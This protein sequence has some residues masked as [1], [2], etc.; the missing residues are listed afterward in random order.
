[1]NKS[2]KMNQ[3]T[4]NKITIIMNQ[5]TNNK[6]TIIINSMQNLLIKIKHHHYIINKNPLANED[7]ISVGS[8][9]NPPII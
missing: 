5:V 8:N 4:I 3:I 7:N 6:M 2:V 1:M 9:E